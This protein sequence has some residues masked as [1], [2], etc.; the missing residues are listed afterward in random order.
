MRNR[1]I[2]IAGG[3]SKCDYVIIL[4]ADN[5]METGFVDRARRRARGSSDDALGKGIAAVVEAADRLLTTDASDK[6][7]EVAALAK[8]EYLHKDAR[9]GDEQADEDL[10]EFVD[11]L[12]DSERE[13]ISAEIEF[14]LLERRAINVDELDRERVIALLAELEEFFTDQIERPP[15]GLAIDPGDVFAK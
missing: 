15:L 13:R 5:R 10:T 4:D 12:K 6:F 3:K 1:S 8:L 9:L 2:G 7:K 11:Q 14:L